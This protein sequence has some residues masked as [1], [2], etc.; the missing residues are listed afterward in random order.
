MMGWDNADI[1]LVC[2]ARLEPEDNRRQRRKRIGWT[3]RYG[4]EEP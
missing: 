2:L 1:G 4:W 3:D